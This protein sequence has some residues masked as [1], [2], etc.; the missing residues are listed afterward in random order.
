MGLPKTSAMMRIKIIPENSLGCWAH[1]RTPASPTIPIANLRHCQLSYI[2]VLCRDE[3]L[4]PTYPVASPEIPTEIPAPSCINPVNRANFSFSVFEIITA[5]TRPYIDTIL[6]I[7][8]GIISI[9][10]SEY[11]TNVWPDL[12]TGLTLHHPIRS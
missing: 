1:P 12:E 2:L 11:Q 4:E 7:M 10:T 8:G 5:M 9:G 3:R 6:A